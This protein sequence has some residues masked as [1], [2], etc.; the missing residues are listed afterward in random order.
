MSENT[1]FAYFAGRRE[2]IRIERAYILDVLIKRNI[3]RRDALNQLVAMNTEGTETV[4]VPE[5]EIGS[6]STE[7][8]TTCHCKKQP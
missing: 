2:G 1:E 3:I 6:K 7:T 4:Y 5:L 8:E